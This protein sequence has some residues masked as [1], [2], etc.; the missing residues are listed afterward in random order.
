[1]RRLEAKIRS[2]VAYFKNRRG[3][4]LHHVLFVVPNPAREQALLECVDTDSPTFA[5]S[6]CRFWVTS[7][8]YLDAGGVLGPIWL[9]ARPKKEPVSTRHVVWPGPTAER[10]LA[11]TDFPAC[12]R[13]RDVSGCIAKLGWWNQRPGGAD[14]P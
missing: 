5:F 8:P 3:A 14:G 9:Y 4:E 10:R 13:S 6:G 1:M 12:R 2:Y 7:R 11:L